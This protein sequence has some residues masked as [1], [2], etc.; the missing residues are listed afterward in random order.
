LSG[1]VPGLA[2]TIIQTGRGLMNPQTSKVFYV[3]G[4]NRREWRS[5]LQKYF[6]DSQIPEEL[7]GTMNQ[8]SSEWNEN[9]TN[10]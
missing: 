7:G 5:F 6:D 3:F 8:F 10:F 2:E 9:E 1:A 4:T